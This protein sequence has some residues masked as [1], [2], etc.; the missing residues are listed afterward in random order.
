MTNGGVTKS[1]VKLTDS[2]RFAVLCLK[3]N[4]GDTKSVSDTDS[5]RFTPNV[6]VT[7]SVSDTDSNRFTPNVGVTKSVSDTDSD[8][9]C[10]HTIGA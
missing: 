9:S 8:R 7:K 5:N 10:G 4:G 2:D 3:A 6:G 1:A